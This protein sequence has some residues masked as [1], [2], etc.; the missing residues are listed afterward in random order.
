[1]KAP[2]TVLP[3]RLLITEFPSCAEA[4][5]LEPRSDASGAQAGCPAC[6]PSRWD[7]L[8]SCSG[9]SADEKAGE[10]GVGE[11][12]GHAVLGGVVR[13]EPRGHEDRE[14]RRAAVDRHRA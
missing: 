2:R 5:R 14:V 8:A 3:R 13:L 6:A 11:R 12:D 9:A 7:W 4:R 10:R 1:M